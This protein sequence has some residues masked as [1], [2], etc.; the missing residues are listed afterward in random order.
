MHKDL[1][2]SLAQTALFRQLSLPW[3]YKYYTSTN[4]LWRL[5]L[6][7]RWLKTRGSIKADSYTRRGQSHIQTHLVVHVLKRKLQE[8]LIGCSHADD[9]NPRTRF[10][11]RLQDYQSTSESSRNKSV[12]SA[13]LL[14]ISLTLFSWDILG[15]KSTLWCI[16][17]R[18]K[19]LIKKEVVSD[20]QTELGKKKFTVPSSE[21]HKD[22]FTPFKFL[23]WREGELL[24]GF[25]LNIMSGSTNPY[26]LKV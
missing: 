5:C 23:N 2:T 24:T 7:W 21:E 25:C 13:G 14:W 1:N 12:L 15:Y 20:A 17:S 18:V 4:I 19:K 26:W 16:Y 9:R 11:T 22:A 8:A 3:L 6:W 10:L